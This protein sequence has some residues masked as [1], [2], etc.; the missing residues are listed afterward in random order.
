[1]PDKPE[2]TLDEIIKQVV[3]DVPKVTPLGRMEAGKKAKL[4]LA[5]K[6]EPKKEYQHIIE[7]LELLKGEIN[8]PRRRKKTKNVL[9]R[10]PKDLAESGI[11]ELCKIVSKNTG[12][13]ARWLSDAIEKHWQ[14]GRKNIKHNYDKRIMCCQLIHFLEK[15]GVSA[16]QAKIIT[17]K[18]YKFNKTDAQDSYYYFKRDLKKYYFPELQNKKY[19]PIKILL[20]IIQYGRI[21][22]VFVIGGNV[23]KKAQNQLRHIINNAV[24]SLKGEIEFARKEKLKKLGVEINFIIPEFLDREYQAPE[25]FILA[26]QKNDSAKGFFVYC[27]NQFLNDMELFWEVA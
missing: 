27:V 2:P 9:D 11:L 8:K 7:Y 24:K 10:S 4:K 14:A 21:S 25:A 15:E 19:I 23:T 26:V 1:M 18:I 16:R 6:D 22:G 17:D 20:N 5:E 13:N 3:A 12:Y